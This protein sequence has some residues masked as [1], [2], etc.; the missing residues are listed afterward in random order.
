MSAS[1]A[2]RASSIGTAASGTAVS[3]AAP[4]GATAGDLVLVV[5]H[6]NNLTTI[7]DNNGATPFTESLNDFQNGS[8][9]H[10]AALFTRRL[11]AGDPAAYNFTLGASNR[12]TAVA[13][14]FKDPHPDDIF[15]A[16]IRTAIAANG[17][18]AFAVPS[19]RTVTAGAL[20]CAIFCADFAGNSITG[21]P[22]GYTIHQNGGDQDIAFATKAIET[23][24]GT[25][26]TSWTDALDDGKIGISFAIRN[27]RASYDALLASPAPAFVVLAEVQPMEVLGSWTAAGG[28]FTNTYYCAFSTQIATTIVAGGLYRRLDAVRQNATALT[29]RASIALVDANLGSYFHDTATNRL[30]VST[31][32][33]A[34]P[35]NF[36]LVGAWF[37]LFFATSSID[38]SDQPLYVPLIT[39]DLPTLVS[40]M[41]DQLFGASISETGVLTLLNGD[42]LFDRLSQQYV[43]RNKK[44]TIKLGGVGLAYSDFATVSTLRI[45][46]MTV[47]DEVATLQLEAM[48]TILNRSLPTRTWGDT[49]SIDDVGE[50]VLGQVQPWILGV[51]RDCPLA[52]TSKTSNG[53]YTVC[54]TGVT[55]VNPTVDAVYAIHRTTRAKTQLVMTTDY[56]QS[57]YTIT[58]VNATYHYNTYEI[59]ADL[60]WSEGSAT[61][62]VILERLLS[63]L[64]EA[65]ANV[66]TAAF[67][68]SV[69][70]V[71]SKVL[72]VY[73]HT[74]T[75][76]ADVA[77]IFEQSEWVQLY[78]GADGR[79]TIRSM[80]PDIPATYLSLTDADF[81]SWEVEHAL[82]TV[83]SEARIQYDYRAGSNSAA[84]STS[85][86]DLT[87]YGSETTDSHRLFTYIVQ[88]ADA[89][90]LAE[91]LRFFRSRPA[92]LI[93]FEE[94]GLTLM[95][96][97]VGDVV[98]VTRSRA[99]VARTG[100]YHGHFLR[101][102][103]LEKSLGPVP[104]VRGLLNDLDGQ[105]DRIA[106]CLGA[107]VDLNW[108]AATNEQRARYGFCGDANRYLDGTR[109]LK[110]VY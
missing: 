80:A 38:F 71:N 66:D 79:W 55:A 12:W 6:C 34:T 93:R 77:R 21:T 30:Y 78:V 44:A 33:G 91:H 28:G 39:G 84:E 75:P 96:A 69:L 101:L 87:K 29:S 90:V 3:V 73:T 103:R 102:V 89:A 20:H 17:T 1:T 26:T 100:A 98:S 4:A 48:G 99:P 37:T 5:V 9:S 56:T 52:L 42:G 76:A 95:Q 83:L 57:V 58:I 107:D 62:G 31:T 92:A 45:N 106:R 105:V 8:T 74:S 23:P 88:G 60:T 49:F 109:D 72:G 2:V 68:V 16:S 70:A 67:A 24:S 15:D 61:C 86:S 18:G 104:V 97:Q 14:A 47:S 65:I 40:E 110:V 32:S 7:V 50:G 36:A 13:V 81:V 63:Y 108:S 35:D 11:V 25:G 85:S 19:V 59:W 53:S 54:D 94:R 43:W 41:P 10:T 82:Q 27:I 46:S 64:G 22:A 51:A